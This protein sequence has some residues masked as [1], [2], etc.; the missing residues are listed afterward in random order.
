MAQMGYLSLENRSRIV[1]LHL[2]DRLLAELQFLDDLKECVFAVSLRLCSFVSLSQGVSGLSNM[3]FCLV[4]SLFNL[5][6]RDCIGISVYFAQSGDVGYDELIHGS[7]QG[8]S[9]D[10]SRFLDCL[11]WPIQLET[12]SGYTGH[13]NSTLCHTTPYF[14]DRK[15]EV[16]F[17]VPYLM[18]STFPPSSSSPE[19]GGQAEIPHMLDHQLVDQF[20][21]VTMQDRVAVVWVEDRERMLNLLPLLV[22]NDPNLMVFLLIHPLG[23][24]GDSAGGLFWIR[25]V[26][27]QGITT[28]TAGSVRLAANPLMIGPL[29]DGMLVSRHSLGSLVRNTAISADRACRLMMESFSEPSAARARY[30]QEVLQN[31]HQHSFYRANE[32]EGQGHGQGHGQGQGGQQQQQPPQESVAEFYRTMFA[33]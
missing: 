12:H 28:A 20:R 24:G 11:G 8:L 19:E 33:M 3:V 23:G 32:E 13:L 10:F 1:P 27:P 31:H 16:I 14:A 29:A 25:I 21:N 15:N 26:V 18:R 22:S 9:K 2:S 6:R 7:P 17:H 4:S 5:S 30:I